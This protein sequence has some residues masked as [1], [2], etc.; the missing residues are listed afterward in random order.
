MVD[1]RS[2][3]DAALLAAHAK[4]DGFELSRLY[5]DA[6]DQAERD[7]DTDAVCFFLTQAYVSAL[8]TGLPSAS[9]LNQR[10]VQYGREVVQ[11]DLMS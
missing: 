2:D 7:Q 4:G 6:A 10:L 3:L 9:V 8:E 1:V 11:A 5:A